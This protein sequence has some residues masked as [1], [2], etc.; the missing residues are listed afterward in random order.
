MQTKTFP[1]GLA[2]FLFVNTDKGGLRS[3]SDSHYIT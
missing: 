3:I 1:K 2:D